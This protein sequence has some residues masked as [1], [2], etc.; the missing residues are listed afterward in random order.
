MKKNE[1]WKNKKLGDV[2][3]IERGGSPRPIEQFITNDENGINWIKIG[4]AQEGTMIISSTKQKIKP[5]GMSKSRFVRKGDFIL[6]NSMSF[7]KP[8]ILGIDGCI[9]DGWLVIRDENNVFDKSYLYYF[10]GCK[11]TYQTFKKMAVGGVVNNLNS[12]MVRGLLIPIPPIPTQHQIVSELD[13]LSDII[14]K[15]KQQLEELDKLAQATF[16]DMFGDPVS[17]EKGWVTKKLGE[18]C[19]KITDGKHG[20]CIDESESGCYFVSAKDINGR[21]IKT[22]NARQI[23]YSDFIETNNRTRLSVN[24]V[25]VVNTGATIGKTAIAN[26]E[27]VS[28]RLTFQKSVAIITTDSKIL[29]FNFLELYIHLNK[30]EIYKEASGSA[31]KNWLLSQMRNYKILLPPLKIQIEF[32]KLIE[33]I[34]KQKELINKS[35][36]DVQLLFD[37]TMDKYFN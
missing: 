32:A 33:K 14:T 26:Q 18:V 22:E 2:C 19:S 16:Y 4:D 30:N 12:K 27:D 1:D 6:S 10:L 29:D 15:K 31:Q 28:K 9:H 36:D 25:V 17:N 37:Y 13:A 8:Y 24:D 20:D 7:G 5:E 35:I 11:Y 23:T 21:K 3:I 34:E